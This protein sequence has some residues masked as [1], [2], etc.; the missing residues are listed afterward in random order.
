MP[1]PIAPRG[2][3]PL[4]WNCPARRRMET[5]AVA[6]LSTSAHG[7]GRLPAPRLAADPSWL[8]PALPGAS[9]CRPGV[10]HGTLL[11]EARWRS[12]LPP[13]FNVYKSTLG[14]GD[15]ERDAVTIVTHAVE[16]SRTELSRHRVRDR[17]ENVSDRRRD[18]RVTP[19][20]R[21]FFGYRSDH[22]T[23]RRCSPSRRAE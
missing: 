2:V 20:V 5:E 4:T 8:R 17:S 21:E 14:V 6:V 10:A 23:A 3:G 11:R 15:D 19:F 9:R 13:S 16:F 22:A 12:T 18:P 7:D 1:C